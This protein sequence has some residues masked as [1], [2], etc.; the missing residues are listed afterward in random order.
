VLVYWV[1]IWFNIHDMKIIDYKTASASD[2]TKLD[3]EVNSLIQRGYQPY[4]SPYLSEHPVE[5]VVEDFAIYQAMVLDE[6]TQRKLM[7]KPPKAEIVPPQK[8]VFDSK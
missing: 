5:G 4:G 6:E 8:R 7:G 1:C 3:A 2:V